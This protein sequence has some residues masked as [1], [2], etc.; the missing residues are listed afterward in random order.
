MI[1]E[2]TGYACGLFAHSKKNRKRLR[3]GRRKEFEFIDY[4]GLSLKK[5]REKIGGNLLSQRRNI[6]MKI[7]RLLKSRID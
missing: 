5:R 7:A 6:E 1:I 4:E 2:P 3:K